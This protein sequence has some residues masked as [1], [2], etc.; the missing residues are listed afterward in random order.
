VHWVTSISSQHL[1]LFNLNVYVYFF[2]WWI[3]SW[4]NNGLA[5]RQ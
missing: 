1:V 3:T 5:R 2:F 4:R